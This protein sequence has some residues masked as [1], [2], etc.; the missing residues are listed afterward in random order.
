MQRQRKKQTKSSSR[1]VL[2]TRPRVLL[3]ERVLGQESS[4]TKS[5][6]KKQKSAV[7]GTPTGAAKDGKKKAGIRIEHLNYK[8]CHECVA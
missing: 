3:T 4:S 6:K 7:H 8:V 5:V 1:C 2:L